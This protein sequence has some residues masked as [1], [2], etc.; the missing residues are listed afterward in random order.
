MRDSI[1]LSLFSDDRAATDDDIPDANNVNA[2]RGG[3]WAASVDTD[4]AAYGSKLWIRTAK[5]PTAANV[6]ALEND[7]R[8]ALQW[9]I[10]DGV[11]ELIDVSAERT[12]KDRVDMELKIIRCDGG[13]HAYRFDDL[14]RNLEG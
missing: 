4:N 5:P 3:W 10:D 1:L 13:E 14:W 9:M 8:A 11:C 2:Y 6:L 12:A 7:T